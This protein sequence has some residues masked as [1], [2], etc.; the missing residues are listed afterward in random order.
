MAR[1]RYTE[2]E[3]IGVLNEAEAGPKLRSCV[4]LPARMVDAV[5]RVRSSAPRPAA[6]GPLGRDRT[7]SFGLT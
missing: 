4:A 6:T 2:K 1:K 3:I 7:G 5:Q